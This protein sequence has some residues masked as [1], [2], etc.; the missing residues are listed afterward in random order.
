MSSATQTIVRER[1]SAPF[2][3]LIAALV[4]GFALLALFIWRWND[5]EARGAMSI[6]TLEL[7]T[8]GD[9]M[10]FDRTELKVRTGTMVKVVF[11]N[12]SRLVAMEHNWAVVQPG[13]ELTVAAAGTAA[14]REN[15]Y[16]RPNDPNVIAFTKLAAPGESSS[17]TFPAPPPGNYPYFCA[18]PGHQVTMKGALVVTP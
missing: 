13:T 1:P 6:P 7:G 11:H 5:S 12:N 17:V 3:V 10:A 16:L 15:N 14:G 9:S 8:Q 18:F 4:F 2:P